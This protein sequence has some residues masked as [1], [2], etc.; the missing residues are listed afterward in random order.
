MRHFVRQ[1]NQMK[2]VALLAN[3]AKELLSQ[4]KNEKN[5]LERYKNQLVEL[6]SLATST[7]SQLKDI[8][9]TSSN[10]NTFDNQMARISDLKTEIA[11]QSL[12]V[13]IE[14][15]K[16]KYYVNSLSD[17][18]YVSVIKL[19]YFEDLPWFEVQE[20]MGCSERAMYSYHGL[21]LKEIN[22]MM[23]VQ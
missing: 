9:V 20:E 7:T 18:K 11:N 22:K 21:A 13:S 23:D 17:D 12:L 8:V 19:R 4:F 15:Q 10:T 1:D 14:M 6:N 16:L 2:G 5:K 3:P